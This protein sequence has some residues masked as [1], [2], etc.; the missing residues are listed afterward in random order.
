M[1][2]L[3]SQL[4]NASGSKEFLLPYNVPFARAQYVQTAEFCKLPRLLSAAP[5]HP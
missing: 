3:T 4:Y 1:S 2:L 5:K